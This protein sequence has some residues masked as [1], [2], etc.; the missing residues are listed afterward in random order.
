MKKLLLIVG[1]ILITAGVLFLLFGVLNWHGYYHLLDGSPE[2]YISMHRR[3]I[4]GFTIG[5][6]LAV[7]GILCFI[8]RTKM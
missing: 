4:V 6:V 7:I 8:L 3:M 1:I 2:H 5:S